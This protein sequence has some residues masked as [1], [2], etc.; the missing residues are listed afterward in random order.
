M[1]GSNKH[2]DDVAIIAN[3]LSLSLPSAKGDVSI[4]KTISFS[5]P[6]HKKIAITGPSGSG[7]TSLLMLLAGLEKPTNGE[8]SVYGHALHQLSNEQLTEIRNR[9]I[10]IVFQ[11]FHLLPTMTALENVALPLELRGDDAFLWDKAKDTLTQV[12][13]E[14]RL[15]HYPSQLSGGEQQRTAIARA[16][17][18][19][20]DML[21]A[22]EPTGNLD[23]ATGEHIISMLFNMQQLY[24]ATLLL[25]THDPSLAQRCDIEIRM[26]DGQVIDIIEQSS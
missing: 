20:P 23:Q 8:L 25:I 1:R 9:H 14:H 21:L 26:Q 7:K 4:L 6:K 5:V 3:N 22:D 13:L 17:V 15:S 16:C 11:E 24:G 18:G 2:N 10:G 12:G 19:K